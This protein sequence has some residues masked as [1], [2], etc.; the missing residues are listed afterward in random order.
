MKK[1]L[2]ALGA[3]AAVVAPVV[4]LA[5]RAEVLRPDGV[6]TLEDAIG[7]CRD[8]GLQGWDLVDHAIDLVARK[9]SKYSLWHLWESP[10]TSFAHSRGYSNKYNVA[11]AI[12]L[13]GL[14]FRV[15]TVHAARVQ[16]FG[17][18]WW[19]AGHTWLLVTHDGQT[20]DACASRVGNR[21]GELGFTPLS[22]E[23]SVRPITGVGIACALA[24]IV[25]WHVWK[26]WL[27]GRPV[28][29][30]IYRDFDRREA[31]A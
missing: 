18:P 13:R 8:T 10:R 6:E 31:R 21:T 3:A 25:V 15:R 14:G 5:P 7:A 2:V 1:T 11:L 29:S 4:A 28:S 12:V 9:Y 26:A 27:T 23:L 30:T 22:D 24:P 16:G 20:R 19:R 17:Q